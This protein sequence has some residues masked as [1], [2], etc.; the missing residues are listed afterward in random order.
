[1]SQSASVVGVKEMMDNYYISS[2]ILVNGPY[3]YQH[4]QMA[5]GFPF[6]KSK[7]FSIG[8]V[9]IN[10][11]KF[12]ELQLNYDVTRQLL[13]LFINTSES[14]LI[15]SLSDKVVDS[16]YIDNRLFV[17]SKFVIESSSHYF[18][19]LNNGNYRMYLGYEKEFI[20]RFDN[21][22]PYGRYSK[23]QRKIFVLSDIDSYE[24]TSKES[25]LNLFPVHRKEI[26]S[27]LKLNKLRFK[28]ASYFELAKLM[29]FCNTIVE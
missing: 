26:K 14:K 12:N 22:D 20:L 8:E 28:K 10:G 24:I 17:N 3:Y 9:Y 13:V 15:I 23:S 7:E 4:H 5:N 19:Q 25:F 1:M 6:L 21:E 11:R 18:N 2:D 27:Y 29:V 16:F